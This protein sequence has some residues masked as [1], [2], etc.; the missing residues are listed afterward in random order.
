MGKILLA[1]ALRVKTG[2]VECARCTR[3]VLAFGPEDTGGEGWGGEPIAWLC[4]ESDGV[5]VIETIGLGDGLRSDMEHKALYR[6]RILNLLVVVG[7]IGPNVFGTDAPTTRPPDAPPPVLTAAPS[8]R[9]STP[10]VSSGAGR[11]AIK[12]SPPNKEGPNAFIAPQLLDSLIP[13]T[14]VLPKFVIMGPREK[15]TEKDV[16]TDKAR[17]ATAEKRYLTPLYRAAFGPL[18]QLAAYYF[19]WTTLLNGWHPNEYE[20][21]ALYRQDE[22]LKRRVEM[23]RLLKLEATENAKETKLPSRLQFDKPSDGLYIKIP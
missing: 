1:P 21:M 4:P 16:L 3:P 13:E 9:P 23:D 22:L 2:W 15:L 11:L 7:M 17:L 6:L 10:S 14:V 18:S 20:A 19:D 5:A 12:Y 8:D